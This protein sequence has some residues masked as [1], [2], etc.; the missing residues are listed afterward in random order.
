MKCKLYKTGKEKNNEMN[1][2]S[3]NKYQLIEKL[4][5]M[6]NRLKKSDSTSQI[7]NMI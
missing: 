7:N 6:S 3:I 4:R 2:E 5:K 1:L